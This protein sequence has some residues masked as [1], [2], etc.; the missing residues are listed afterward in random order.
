[1]SYGLHEHKHVAM[2]HLF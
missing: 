2:K 1:M